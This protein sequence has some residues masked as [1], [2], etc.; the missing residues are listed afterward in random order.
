KEYFLPGVSDSAT[1]VFTVL[2]Q[3]PTRAVCLGQ[4]LARPMNFP[5]IGQ[6]VKTVALSKQQVD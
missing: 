6:H 4:A 2:H 3:A 1:I 5:R